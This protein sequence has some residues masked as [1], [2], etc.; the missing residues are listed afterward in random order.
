MQQP[1]APQPQPQPQLAWAEV[2]EKAE[3]RLVQQYR[4]SDEWAVKVESEPAEAIP[5]LAA[6]LHM[7]LMEEFVNLFSARLPEAMEH[8]L[9]WRDSTRSKEAAFFQAYPALAEHKEETQ[10]IA[11]MWRQMN[12]AADENTAIKGIG[13]VAMAALGLSAVA[14]EPPR[15]AV[16]VPN[17]TRHSPPVGASKARSM[18]QF[19]EL[20]SGWD[21]E[22]ID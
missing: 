19:E 15:A 4:L 11:Q 9:Q 16:P 5:Q 3:Q 2:R 22:D 14:A 10:K 12:P 1:V 17:V 18:N 20:N 7:N 6:M 8:H 13:A 21:E